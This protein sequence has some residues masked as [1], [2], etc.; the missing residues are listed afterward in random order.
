QLDLSPGEPIEVG[1]LDERTIETRRADLEPIAARNRVVYIER[2]R[3][4][5]ADALAVRHCDTERRIV[6]TAEAIDQD[7]QHRLAV[8]GDERDLDELHPMC[9]ADGLHD[10]FDPI[11]VDSSSH[12]S[13]AFRA[14]FLA[15]V[16]LCPRPVRRT[17]IHQTA[18]RPPPV[19][20]SPRAGGTK[21]GGPK[22]P[23][24][25]R[26]ERIA[27]GSYHAAQKRASRPPRGASGPV[28]G[29][30]AGKP[31]GGGARQAISSENR[32]PRPLRTEPSQKPADAPA[33]SDDVVRKCQDPDR[34][35]P[36]LVR[37]PQAGGRL[38]TSLSEF[39]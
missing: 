10:G 26:P 23:P 38:L 32:R 35:P 24:R 9:P 17:T 14:F 8:L 29:S 1:E 25:Q 31:R 34:F 33:F 12:Y 39:P 5:P 3:E 6:L 37:I 28:A 30:D 2:R 19:F 36:I 13:A 15:R 11:D 16:V 18:C 4:I 7:A 20:M 27:A 22:G 21:S